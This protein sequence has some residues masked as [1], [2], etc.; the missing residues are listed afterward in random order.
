MLIYL[1]RH[2]ETP[3]N[4]ARIV[5]KPEVPLSQ[6][7]EAQA[8]RL[9]RRLANAG[10]TA[11]L[12]SDLSRAAMTAEHLS[13]ALGELRRTGLVRLARRRLTVPDPDAL[14]RYADW[15][16]GYLRPRPLF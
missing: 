16:D 13:R 5:Q 11:I 8:A 14:A 1:I 9:A 6:R 4:A 7:G 15:T 3:G 12:A 10:I 2:G